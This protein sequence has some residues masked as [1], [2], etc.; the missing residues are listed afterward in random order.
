MDRS[1][2]PSRTASSD[3]NIPSF[4]GGHAGCGQLAWPA[5]PAP[6]D[7]LPS[8]ALLG[9]LE[10]REVVDQMLDRMEG[11]ASQPGRGVVVGCPDRR[12]ELVRAALQ[13]AGLAH[14]GGGDFAGIASGGSM[15]GMP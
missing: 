6:A 12:G 3:C 5:L 10:T 4:A 15:M 9:L 7:G 14:K 2:S 8:A 11:L 13:G 1:S